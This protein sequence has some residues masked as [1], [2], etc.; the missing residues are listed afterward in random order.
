MRTLSSVPLFLL[1]LGFLSSV[2]SFNTVQY[3][4]GTL[5]EPPCLSAG[6]HAAEHGRWQQPL[7]VAVELSFVSFRSELTTPT[8]RGLSHIY[9][10]LFLNGDIY[11]AQGIRKDA[12]SGF[13][14]FGTGVVCL[15][16]CG[17]HNIPAHLGISR[18]LIGQRSK[19]Q[20]NV[21]TTKYLAS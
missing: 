5:H 3:N 2:C 20:E 8:R 17:R 9:L 12:L 19:R 10:L 16:Y 4:S 13:A 14:I 1:C 15:E 11:K 7:T 21:T 18:P 6:S